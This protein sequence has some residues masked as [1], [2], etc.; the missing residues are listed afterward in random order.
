MR[1]SRPGRA[2]EKRRRIVLDTCRGDRRVGCCGRLTRT[3]DLVLTIIACA[4]QAVRSSRKN[5]QFKN[6]AAHRADRRTAERHQRQFPS[7]KR[8]STLPQTGGF[9]EHGGWHMATCL[10]CHINRSLRA[11]RRASWSTETTLVDEFVGPL[12]MKWCRTKLD[13]GA[14]GLFIHVLTGDRLR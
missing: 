3:F 14:V 9:V 1:V 2:S 4:L 12:P 8:S 7:F 6:G 11:S 5:T 10:S 13:A